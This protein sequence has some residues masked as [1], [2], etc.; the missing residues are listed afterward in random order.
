MPPSARS[1]SPSVY[2]LHDLSPR[3]TQSLSTTSSS[4]QSQPDQEPEP[5]GEGSAVPPAE[6]AKTPLA[7]FWSSQVSC[8][9]DFSAA[10][11]HLANERTFLGYLRTSMMMSMVGTL[12]AQLFTFN[13]ETN[14]GS[15]FGYFAAGKPLAI[16]C[17]AFSIGTILLGAVRSWRHQHAMLSGK[18]LSGGFEIH[19]LGICSVL[20]L[21]VF[22]GFLL[23]IDVVKAVS[24]L[25]KPT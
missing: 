21:F 11:D 8:E 14:H 2:S 1:R 13:H 10:R 25:P 3:I 20:L 7:R 17:Y 18:A 16:T 6:S 19:C 22:F 5:R 9:V 23:A 15:G 24:P 12:V 4:P